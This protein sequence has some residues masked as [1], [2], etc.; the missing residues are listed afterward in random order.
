MFDLDWHE[1]SAQASNPTSPTVTSGGGAKGKNDILS[2]FSNN[3]APP[4]QQFQQQVRSPGGMGGLDSFGGM[5][6]GSN[7]ASSPT[8]SF[9]NFGGASNQSQNQNPLVGGGMGMSDPWASNSN[10]NSS[11]NQIGNKSRGSGGVGA[12]SGI[13][14]SHDIWG[15]PAGSNSNG[16]ASVG[17]GN[18][19]GGAKKDNAFDDLW[20]DF[21]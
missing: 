20:S 15:T 11:T 17:N 21:K 6:L 13:F 5:N 9:N 4:Q 7:S 3:T 12:G 16:N 2:L 10:S 8:S 19:L 18:G 14:D 1:P